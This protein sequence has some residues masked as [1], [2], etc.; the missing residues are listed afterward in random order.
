MKNLDDYK[1]EM[2]GLTYKIQNSDKK[3]NIQCTVYE[4]KNGEYGL[5]TISD[6]TNVQKYEKQRVAG[7]FKIMFLQSISHDLRTP[8]NSIILMCEHVMNYYK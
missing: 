4:G 7:I 5:I 1:K 8:I 2:E 3:L 6:V